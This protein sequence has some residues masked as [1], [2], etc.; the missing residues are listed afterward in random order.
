MK[1]KPFHS[2]FF[3]D[4]YILELSIKEKMVFVYYVFNERVNWLGTYEVAD[5]TALFELGSGITIEELKQIADR[6]QKD[7]KIH[8]HENWVIVVN[9]EKYD[10][11][12]ENSQLMGSAFKQYRS[13]PKEIQTLFWE[14]KP[15]EAI[16]KYKVSFDL[17]TTGSLPVAEGEETIQ[18]T[19]EQG[20]TS[21][22]KER[23]MNR[24]ETKEMVDWVLED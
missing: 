2:K 24:E 16:E 22:D 10:T 20:I 21:D 6:F 5:K 1:S 11:H 14:L 18:K 23:M 3:S 17:L 7:N 12:M 4:S 8:F 19:K 13:L 15:E 9:S